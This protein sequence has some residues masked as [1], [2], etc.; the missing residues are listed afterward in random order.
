[1]QHVPHP[2]LLLPG[3]ERGDPIEGRLFGEEREACR[4]AMREP[5]Q[6]VRRGGAGKGGMGRVRPPDDSTGMSTVQ[7]GV[8]AAK[9]HRPADGDDHVDL[10]LRVTVQVET[11][12]G[13]VVRRND[14]DRCRLAN[15]V[16]G[17]PVRQAQ[18]RARLCPAAGQDRR[19]AGEKK[20]A[21]SSES[22]HFVRALLPDQRSRRRGV[23][24][25]ENGHSLPPRRASR[26]WLPQEEP[27]RTYRYLG[28]WSAGLV[29]A[30]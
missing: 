22:R 4:L 28:A 11:L 24:R 9:G 17:K 3:H 1:L 26:L 27:R 2:A 16:V 12:V 10:S 6:W 30:T 7:A 13:A 8:E 18:G 5:V 19:Q 14:G 23:P 20:C 15:S 25:A 29:G 21:Y